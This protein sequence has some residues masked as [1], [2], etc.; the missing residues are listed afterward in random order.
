MEINLTG[1]D[2]YK[3]DVIDTWNMQIIEENTVEPGI[4]KYK[5]TLPFTALRIYRNNE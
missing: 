1:E 5:T 4:V 2:N 3:M